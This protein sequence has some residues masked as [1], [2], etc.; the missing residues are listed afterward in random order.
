M[1]TSRV[2]RDVLD[3]IYAVRPVP[4]GF[5]VDFREKHG[6]CKELS[7]QN[8]EPVVHKTKEAAQLELD[9][10]AHTL[11]FDLVEHGYE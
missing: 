7:E 9:Y 10:M 6:S 2:Y 4:G 11:G 3:R 8:P 5:V 1:M